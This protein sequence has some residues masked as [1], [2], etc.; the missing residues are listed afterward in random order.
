[1][2]ELPGPTQIAV[3]QVNLT[4]IIESLQDAIVGMTSLV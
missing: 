2:I 4:S 1:M 3:Q